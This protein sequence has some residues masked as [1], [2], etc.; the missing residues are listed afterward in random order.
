[1]LKPGL[2]MTDDIATDFDLECIEGPCKGRTSFYQHSEAVT[3]RQVEIYYGRITDGRWKAAIVGGRPAQSIN[4]FPGID[5]QD[6]EIVCEAH[7]MSECHQDPCDSLDWP[8]SRPPVGARPTCPPS[9]IHAI[10]GEPDV[11]ID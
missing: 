7:G 4:G 10:E 8:D 2:T 6:G 11:G 5:L 3:A 1:M 9:F